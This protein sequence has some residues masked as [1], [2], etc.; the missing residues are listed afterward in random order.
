MKVCAPDGGVSPGGV[1]MYAR[2]SRPGVHKRITEGRITAFMFHQVVG[3]TRRTK[4][5]K[6]ALGGR[7][8]QCYIPVSECRSWAALLEKLT[9]A[10]VRREAL[11]DGG[12]HT[13]VLS[14]GGRR[15]G[16]RAPKG[17]QRG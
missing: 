8:T 7:A 11:G 3:V 16:G 4:Q 13:D 2:V 10:E 5:E 17:G 12:I 14:A 15:R 1:A 6:L 9:P